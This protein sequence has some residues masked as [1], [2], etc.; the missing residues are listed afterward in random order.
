[1][2]ATAIDTQKVE[3][4]LADPRLKDLTREF[5]LDRAAI[6]NN[7]R[8]VALSFASE[9]P[10]ERY[11]GQE[12]LDCTD[13]ACDLSRLRR[14][15]A[16]LMDHNARD[17]VGVVEKC[18]VAGRKCRA[19]V[20][21]SRSARGQEIFQDVID[22]I[23][24]LVS[25]GYQ[26]K[27][28][29]LEQSGQESG[30]RYRVTEWEPYE[31]S[32]VS[33]PADDSVGVG[34]SKL[35][36]QE[37]PTTSNQSRTMSTETAAPAASPATPAAPVVTQVRQDPPA[38]A[39]DSRLREIIA[40]GSNFNVP[41]ARVNQAILQNETLDQFR[42]WVMETHLKATPVA[43]AQNIGMNRTE[44]RR[45]SMT[46]AINRLANRQP[47]EGLEKECSDAAAKQYKREEP[48]GGFIMPHDIAE[49]ADRDMVAAMLRVSPSLGMSRYGQQLQ[50]AMGAG[51]F[52]AAGALI[53]EDF[54]GGSFIE[55]LRNR[56]LLTQLGVGTMSGLV[57]NVV[58]PRQSG[59]ATAYWL[60]EGEAVTATNQT[61]AQVGGT[62]KRL[63]AQTSYSKQLLAQSSLDAEALVRDD[64]VRII[65]IAKDLAGIAGTGGAQPRG[66]LNGP[67]TDATGGGNNITAITFGTSATRANLLTFMSSIQT[68]NADIGTMQWLV[69]PNTRAKWQSIA[70]VPNYP[71]YLTSDEGVTIGYPTPFT[72][73]IGTAGTF[74]N[75]AIFGAW[76]QAMFL[77]WAGYD[78]IVDPYTRAAYNEV[79]TTV[80][81][82]TDF[83][84][85]HW[86]SFA[87]S[88]DSAAQ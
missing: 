10:V 3:R 77:D 39:N 54:L 37:T 23:R 20:R 19:V 57:G 86:P 34:R 33:I 75:R 42:Q 22:G 87:I 53:A 70:Q 6:D 82:F 17:Q 7:A 36:A 49:F 15:G 44:K 88:A 52:T 73:Q 4:V 85:R 71:V 59:A 50:R 40:I 46:R 35:K 11:F 28:M 1:M 64:H 63:S 16:L 25:V 79:V 80:N 47:L 18:E 66:I 74:A 29:V 43:V 51:N 62:P 84:V 78:V 2:S 8:T 12:V 61:F 13:K 69:N 58:I 30:D 67:L 60:A 83:V 65:A 81:L 31:I 48:A 45:Y 26:V 9:V 24:S 5:A 76:G 56:T 38:P 41:Q 32:L 55:L 21:F 68:A 72:N 27:N 14:G